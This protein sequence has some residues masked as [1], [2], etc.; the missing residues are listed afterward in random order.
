MPS[1]R[2]IS[3]EIAFGRELRNLRLKHKISQEELGARSGYHRTYIGQ[4]ERGEKSPSL[5]TLF[6]LAATLGFLPSTLVRTIEK[7]IR[8]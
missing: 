5:R 1:I 4:L 2:R 7:A 6:D 3:P 8:L